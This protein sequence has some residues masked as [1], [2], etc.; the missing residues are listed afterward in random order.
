VAAKLA[1]DV[2][3]TDDNP[4]TEDPVAIRE[5]V[6]KGCPEAQNIGDREEAIRLGIERLEPKDCLVIAGKGHEQGQ[7]IGTEVIPFSDV[8]VAR[9][10]LAE[11]R[12]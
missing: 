4:R 2:I 1:D 10:I 6:M 11:A 9:R 7:I 8:D 12:S 3:V 5:A